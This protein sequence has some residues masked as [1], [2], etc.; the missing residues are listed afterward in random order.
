M[1]LDKFLN[2]CGIGT[3]KQIKEYVK[4]G[5]VKI[6]GEVAK[7]PDISI[8]PNVNEIL[9][10]DEN[11]T[12]NYAEFRYYMMNKPDGVISATSDKHETTVIDLI[13]TGYD[14]NLAPVGRLDKDTVGLLIITNDGKLSHMLLSPKKH[15]EKEYLVHTAKPLSEND[16][17]RLEEGVD[18]GDEDKT[19][20]A[21]A[22][23]DE[24]DENKALHLILH[25]GRFHQVKRMLQAVG[26]EVTYLKRMRMGGLY[27]DESIPEGEY[28][29]LT[30]EEL[31]LLKNSDVSKGE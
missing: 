29:E 6:D 8:D 12:E 4:N 27:L 10:S 5:M 9:F 3:R 30:L 19:L 1:R 25:E 7:K 18:I 16:L 20:P 15:V 26:N 28:R 13:D 14:K 31:K 23:I 22:F 17:R 21:I 2:D 11:L 24:E